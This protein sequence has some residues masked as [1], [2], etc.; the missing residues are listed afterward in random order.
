MNQLIKEI[1]DNLAKLSKDN[2][3]RKVIESMAEGI[4]K[5]I[6]E[7]NEIK[8]RLIEVEAEK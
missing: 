8:E 4:E 3:C 1:S 5:V 2:E 6:A 7:N